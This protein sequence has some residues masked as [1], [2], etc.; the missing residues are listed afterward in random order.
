M[1]PKKQGN[2]K[3]CVKSV[4]LSYS[5]FELSSIFYEK[6]SRQN[7]RGI[8]KKIET[9]SSSYPEIAR[10]YCICHDDMCCSEDAFVY[11]CIEKDLLFL[12]NI[13]LFFRLPTLKVA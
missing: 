9:E 2:K 10:V 3:W 1:Y 8:E 7:L 6:V 13:N 12:K 5:G 11:C 4:C